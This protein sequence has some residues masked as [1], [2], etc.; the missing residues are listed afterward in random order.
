MA[1]CAP[2]APAATEAPAAEA[3][4][5]EAPAAAAAATEAPAAA[6]AGTGY[7]GKF[8][9]MSSATDTK[10]LQ[11]FLDKLNAKFPG[12]EFDF[13]TLSS[14]K[15]T[16]L[17]AA[18]EVA[19]DQI[20]Y[21]DL[22]GQDLRRYATGGKVMDLSDITYK[23]RFRPVGLETYTVKGK[24]WA[25]PV[26][27]IDGFTFLYNKKIFDKIGATEPETY[28]D[29]KALAVE[30]KK[31]GVAPFTHPGKNIYLWPVWHFWAHAQTTGNKSVESTF[32][33]L[34]GD[35]KFTDPENVAALE[36]LYRFAQDGMFIDGVNSLD[37]DGA[38]MSF[39]QGK[40][41][42]FF[43]HVWRIGDIKINP[44]P[45]LDLSLI[46]PVRA[47]SDTN[48]RRQMPGGTGSAECIYSKVAPERKE[49]ALQVLDFWSS[50]ESVKFFNE[51]NASPVSTNANVQASSDPVAL[52][53]AKECADNQTTY[54]D[55]FWPPEITR[56]F[57]E[58]Q[59]ALVA[60]SKNPDEVGADIQKVMDQLYKDG[61]QFEA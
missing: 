38:W 30:L 21:M 11:P 44:M 1:A 43:E 9:I 52:K 31:I 35:L 15:Y 26:G 4:A 17:F 6:A 56:A 42:F 40:G 5:T 36:I 59:Q 41:A 27:G 32:K 20:D 51:L 18:S 13:R 55:W 54:L 22:N 12:V 34:A 47:V 8:V 10:K 53:Y 61:Y 60:G 16:E 14:E 48:V 7:Q 58:G 3:A 45:D 46:A 23:D 29:L 25:L 24:L 49:L 28:D 39:G 19:G 37:S 33:T 57:Q 2:A 50:D